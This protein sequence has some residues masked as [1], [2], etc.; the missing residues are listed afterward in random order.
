[1]LLSN[2]LSLLYDFSKVSKKSSYRKLAEKFDTS[3]ASICR[4]FKRIKSRSHITGA[5]FFKSKEGQEWLSKLVIAA[6]LVFGIVCNIGAERLALFFSLLSITAFAGLS[7]R[8][9]AR[10]E[11]GVEKVIEEYRILHDGKIRQAASNIDIIIGADETFFK[12]LMILVAM[13]LRSG[14]IF[15][16]KIEN[17]R[18]HKTWDRVAMPWLSLFK[19]THCL[20]S[21]R[22]KALIKLAED[23]IKK[24][25]VPD[26]FHL[27]QDISKAIGNPIGVKIAAIN[28]I[29]NNS[30]NSF[31]LAK[32]KILNKT[33]DTLELAQKEYRRYY[34]QL[35]TSLHPFK[36]L[37]SIP[38]NTES[39]KKE[40]QNSMCEIEKIKNN[41]SILDSKDGIG[42][43]NRQIPNATA[44]IDIWWGIVNN[45]LAGTQLVDVQKDWLIHLYLPCI[46]WQNQIAKTDSKEIKK[47]YALSF[48]H[49][50]ELLDKHHL[51]NSMTSSSDKKVWDNWANEMCGF[52]QRTSSAVEGRNGWLSQMHF[53]GRGLSE[54]RLKSQTTIHNYFLKRDNGT[55]ACERLSGIKP[56]CLFEFILKKINSLP[57]SRVKKLDSG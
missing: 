41:L 16:E 14:F 39:S 5:D 11:E 27:M 35:S 42:K 38:H 24:I 54:K 3:I 52:F 22:A 28:K 19:T 12:D 6:I 49:S 7:S 50:K 53:C 4:K 36:V 34:R 1:M 32:A 51:T 21:D 33:K 18:K 10:I 25:S 31:T 40:M 9:I 43:A 55:T 8:S 23:S 48:Q 47:M 44:Q 46:Y 26:L 2:N 45:S 13:E 29:L 56:E 20:V 37:T 57:D 15:S 30:N 17:D